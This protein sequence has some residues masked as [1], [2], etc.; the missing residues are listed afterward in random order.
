M[1]KNKLGRFHILDAG[2]AVD[3]PLIMNQ[4]TTESDI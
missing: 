2:E 3:K 1:D 4:E